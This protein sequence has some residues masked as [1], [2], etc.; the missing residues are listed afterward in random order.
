MFRLDQEFLE[1]LNDSQYFQI[2]NAP[3]NSVYISVTYIIKKKKQFP[4]FISDV[5]ILWRCSVYVFMCDVS[6][7]VISSSSAHTTSVNNLLKYA[8]IMTYKL[9]PDTLDRILS[10][11]LHTSF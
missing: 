8:Y 1:C 7:V 3:E 2:I 4:V 10:T 6:C 9:L 11:A 5:A